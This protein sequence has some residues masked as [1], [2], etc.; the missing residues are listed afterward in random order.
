MTSSQT[1]LFLLETA[2]RTKSL[3]IYGPKSSKPLIGVKNL[4]EFKISPTAILSPSEPFF[5]V[6]RVVGVKIDMQTDYS[7]V[8][9]F[10][11][12]TETSPGGFTPCP[13]DTRHFPPRCSLN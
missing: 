1:G 11:H 13:R 2:S 4:R 12:V 8:S 9:K 5:I 3:F 7:F 6:P 10:K